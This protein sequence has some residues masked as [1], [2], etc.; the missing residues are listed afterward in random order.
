M[1]I[2]LVIV[3]MCI[4]MSYI[5]KNYQK[6]YE[7]IPE[8]SM[9]YK[10]KEIGKL[11][12]LTYNWTYNG[13]TQKKVFEVETKKQ[14]EFTINDPYKQY[15][16]YDFP[17]ENT[18]IISNKRNTDYFKK[19]PERHKMVETLGVFYSL[20]VENTSYSAGREMDD[21]KTYLK[22]M[23]L[24]PSYKLEIGEYLYIDTIT[25]LKQG[26]VDYCMKVI[27][28][29]EDE[30][31][32]AKDYLNTALADTGKIEELA[33]KIKFNN[34]LN[35][36]K[37]EGN[38]LILEYNWHIQKD[39]LKMNNLILFACIPELET[40]TYAPTNKKTSFYNKET[41]ELIKGE[42]ENVVYTREEVDNKSMAN[43]E[44][45]KKFMEQI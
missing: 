41:N 20:D 26:T 31:R 3:F 33:K 28:Y 11:L 9:Y 19:L 39:S 5:E 23:P 30:A 16:E 12:P 13:N 38:N 34:L 2:L 21:S 6:E 7:E 24:N 36:I 29:D 25:Y 15:K 37:V 22:G 43:T 27:A 4:V 8:M 44:N 18:I 35:S 14:G 10:G 17:E 45:L 42:F 32:I 40:I 1:V